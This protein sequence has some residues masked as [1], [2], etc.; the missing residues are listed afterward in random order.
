METVKQGVRKMDN[1]DIEKL[2]SMSIT[3]L[4]KIAKSLRSIA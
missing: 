2:K 1:I 4:S 3:E